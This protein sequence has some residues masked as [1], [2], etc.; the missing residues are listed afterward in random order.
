MKNLSPNRSLTILLKI[1]MKIG[2]LPLADVVDVTESAQ[3]VGANDD[4]TLSAVLDNAEKADDL[5]VVIAAAE[6]AESK[7][8]D[9][10][11]AVLR[12]AEQG[13]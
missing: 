6:K 1:L 10:L 13:R 9:T 7:D 11:G 4:S 3:S 8:K 5:K 12:N 2:K